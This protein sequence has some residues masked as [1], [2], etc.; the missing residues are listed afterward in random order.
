M[1]YPSERT[2]KRVVA[3]L[4]DPAKLPIDLACPLITS[5]NG[6]GQVYQVGVVDQ[7]AEGRGFFAG[8]NDPGGIPAFV[9]A[10]R[11]WNVSNRSSFSIV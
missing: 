9:W 11:I 8:D 7:L 5:M 10:E 4:H 1:C 2:G 6:M 3:I